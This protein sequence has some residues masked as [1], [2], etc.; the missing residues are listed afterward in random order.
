MVNE[1]AASLAGGALQRLQVFGG[2]L[3]CYYRN[4]CIHIICIVIT[5][6]VLGLSR[7]KISSSEKLAI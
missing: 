1:S 5:E 6:Y 3:V 2:E 7:M 4:R